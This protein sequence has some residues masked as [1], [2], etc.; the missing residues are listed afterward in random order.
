MSMMLGGSEE[1]KARSAV[2]NG[3]SADC[4][5]SLAEYRRFVRMCVVCD[6]SNVRVDEDSSEQ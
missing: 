1:T 4:T 6:V 2:L 5:W 3:S